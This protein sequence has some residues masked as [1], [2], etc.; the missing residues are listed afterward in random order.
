MFNHSFRHKRYRIVET[1]KKAKDRV[2]QC[3]PPTDKDKEIEI[4]L[5]HSIS[6][7]DVQIHEALHACLFD[8]DETTIDTVSTDISKF[9]WKLGWRNVSIPK[10]EKLKL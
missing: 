3:D 9:L 4:P 7:L 10:N 6:F 8:L 2:G 5:G 1:D